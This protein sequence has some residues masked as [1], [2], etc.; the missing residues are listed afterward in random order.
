MLNTSQPSTLSQSAQT[1]ARDYMAKTREF[2]RNANLYVLHVIGMDMIHGSFT[3]LFNLYLLALGFDITFIGLRLMI[4]FIAS[5]V[6]AM[7]AGLVSDRIGRKA[8][9]ILGDGRRRG[10]WSRHDQHPERADSAVGSG[11]R[12]LLRQ[13]SPHLRGRLHDGEQQ[14][15]RARPPVLGRGQLPHAVGH[16]RRADRRHGACPVHR[17]HRS[18]RRVP[19]RLLRRAVAVVHIAGAR[20]DAALDRGRGAARKAN[21]AGETRAQPVSRTVRGHPPPTP[22][23]VLRADE[24]AAGRGHRCGGPAAE[25]GVPRGPHPRRGGRNR[26]GV[27]RGRALPRRRDAV[28]AA[29]GG[30]DAQGGRDR[31]DARA[32]AARSSWQWG[33]CRSRWARGRCSSCWPARRTWGAWPPSA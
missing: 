30:A 8:S 13:P 15:E 6:T 23:R 12:R 17:R 3:V 28:R 2:S 7:P 1:Y 33:S 29:R 24:R 21:R 9:F 26:R 16:E 31:A 4:G 14:E 10:D 32:V 5:A 11:P 19:V 22:H 18:R 25:R 20:A 27:R